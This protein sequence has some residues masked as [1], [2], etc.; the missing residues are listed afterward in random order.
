LPIERVFHAGD[1]TP[2][3]LAGTP[4][5]PF[6]GLV[7]AF[8]LLWF[9]QVLSS[10]KF[11]LRGINCLFCLDDRVFHATSRRFAGTPVAPFDGLVIAFSLLWFPQFLSS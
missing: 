10:W 4:M 3:R 2:R 11:F 1:A 7:I 6:D 5:A 9:P 8:S